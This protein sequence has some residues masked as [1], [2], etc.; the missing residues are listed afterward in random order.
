MRASSLAALLLCTAPAVGV[1]QDLEVTAAWGG[2]S[3]PARTTWLELELL[4]QRDG[5]AG[6]RVTSGPQTTQADA[7]L[8]AHTPRRLGLPVRA[9]PGATI[10]V[11]WPD[12]AVTTQPLPVDVAELPLVAWVVATDPPGHGDSPAA[13]HVI[14]LGPGALPPSTAAYDALDALV[15]DDLGISALTQSQL[16]ALLGYLARCGPAVL[17]ALPEQAGRIVMDAAGCGGDGLRFVER[18]DQAM[19]G[20][21]GLQARA[22]LRDPPAMSVS[23]VLPFAPGPWRWV[24][25]L[26]AAYLCL[27][28]WMILFTRR[29]AWLVGA[30][31]AG[32]AASWFTVTFAG[33]AASL[34]VWSEMQQ[35]ERIARYRAVQALSANARGF[36]TMDLPRFLDEPATCQ[37]DAPAEWHWDVASGRLASVRLPTALFGSGAICFRG[38][39]PVL[40]S[41]R[42]DANDDGHVRLAN[43]GE[44]EWPAGWMTLNGKIHGV[45]GMRPGQSVELVSGRGAGAASAVE[46]LALERVG[47]SHEG[48]LLPLAVPAQVAGPDESRAW[49]LLRMPRAAGATQ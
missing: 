5:T 49:L 8:I 10:T 24:T 47:L 29:P 38:H 6:I 22:R 37:P 25:L 32:T 26:V 7:T 14:T 19:A 18:A 45:P 1:A 13:Q 4:S 11:R 39:F 3:R 35:G 30:I 48:L 33:S 44:G 12:G 28:L 20:L 23:S 41:A 31:L 34:G 46:F 21:A 2:W 15:V 9:R 16:G 36:A 17:V 42:L 40:R 43:T 27:V